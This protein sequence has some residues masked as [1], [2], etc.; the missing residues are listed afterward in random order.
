MLMPFA[1]QQSGTV[2]PWTPLSLPLYGWY[3]GDA[4]VPVSTDGAA[5]ATWADQSGSN[6]TLSQATA[7]IQPTFRP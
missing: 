3:K 6:R 4:G 7:I 2:A 1:F 5:V